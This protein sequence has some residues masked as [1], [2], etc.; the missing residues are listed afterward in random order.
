MRKESRV[1]ENNEIE[2]GSVSEYYLKGVSRYLVEIIAIIMS[3]FYLGSAAIGG[4]ALE[5]H[6]GVYVGIT[7]VLIFLIYPINL[8]QK[9]FVPTILD[10]ALAGLSALATFGIMEK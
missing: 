5:Y 2:P 3:I 1:D 4:Q 9:K 10:Y 7:L 6:L 8:G